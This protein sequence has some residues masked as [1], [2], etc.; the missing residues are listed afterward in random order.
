[1]KHWV[2][3]RDQYCWK[4]QSPHFLFPSPAQIYTP[5]TVG[6]FIHLSHSE[7]CSEHQQY[8]D[9]NAL[10]VT[11]SKGQPP[12]WGPIRACCQLL[13]HV[14]YHLRTAEK[15]RQAKRVHRFWWIFPP[16]FSHSIYLDFP[17]CFLSPSFL[18]TQWRKCN[19]F[20]SKLLA[21]HRWWIHLITSDPAKN[22]LVYSKSL[23]WRSPVWLIHHN[24]FFFLNKSEVIMCGAWEPDEDKNIMNYW[25]I[26]D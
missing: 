12:T 19:F 5:L 18:L 4:Q 1:M 20:Y 16:P 3:T 22:P 9:D 10:R 17:F 6:G 7:M 14:N 8:P 2:H 23:S 26:K 25:F 21:N 15:W 11:L 24:C 13:S